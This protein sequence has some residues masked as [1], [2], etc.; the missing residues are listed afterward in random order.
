MLAEANLKAARDQYD[1]RRAAY[2]IDPKSISKDVLDTAEDAVIQAARQPQQL[3][4]RPG[5]TTSLT[6][7]TYDAQAQSVALCEIR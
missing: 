5:V 2:D 4:G 7:K 6:S 3:Q 1:K